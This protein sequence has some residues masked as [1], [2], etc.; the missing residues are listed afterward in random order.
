MSQRKSIVFVINAFETD[1]PTTVT[2]DLASR[3]RCKGWIVSVAAWS[4]GG[5]RWAHA[6][7]LGLQPVLLGTNY[8]S[9]LTRLRSIISKQQPSIL[10]SVLTRPTFGVFTLL[11]FLPGPLTRISADH[12]I[13]EW[14]E[15]GKMVGHILKFV[16]PRVL[17]RSHAVVTVSDSSR[18]DLITAGVRP[19][20]VRIVPNGVTLPATASIDAKTRQTLIE[21]LFPGSKQDVILMG[22]AGNLRDV[23]GYDILLRAFA[24]V[25]ATEPCARLIIWGEGPERPALTSLL[26]QLNLQSKVAMPGRTDRLTELLPCLDMYIQPSRQE[27]FGLATAEAMVSQVAVVAAAVGGLKSLVLPQST[28]LLFEP[29]SSQDLCRTILFMAENPHLRSE[30]AQRGFQHVRDNFSPDQMLA[31]MMAIYDER[32]GSSS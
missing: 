14:S 1:A 4:R 3:L 6:E 17:N 10:Q 16:M 2:L 32:R 12:G 27:S 11:P 31:G 13:H 7:T 15:R 5:P 25:V 24:R 8:I 19:H 20:K 29:E 9:R 21:S 28:G 23:K 26:A 30:L 22:S 18:D